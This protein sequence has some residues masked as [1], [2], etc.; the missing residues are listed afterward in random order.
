MQNF[1]VTALLV[2][3]LVLWGC[4]MPWTS[5]DKTEGEE[6]ASTATAAAQEGASQ[7]GTEEITKGDSTDATEASAGMA[8]RE[9]AADP[10]AESGAGSVTHEVAAAG[11]VGASA[12]EKKIAGIT[13]P[14]AALRD[15]ALACEKAP[16]LY[17]V[18]FS[19][20]KGDFIVNVHRGWAPIGA[21]RL[22]NLVN[23][24][25]FNDVAFFR[26]MK[27]FV[28]QFGIS[29][30][31]EISTAWREA[32]IEDDRVIESNTRGFMSF[33]KSQAPNSRTTQVFINLAGIN[34]Y[35]DDGGYA[36]F[37]RVIEGM[38]IV[39]SLYSDYGDVAPRGPG[40]NQVTIES[41]GNAYLKRDFPD[42]DYVLSAAIIE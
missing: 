12:S 2:A 19:T 26:A 18:K 22:Y 23:I 16:D 30:D 8:I 21:D 37:G 39:E 15:P 14:N 9:G 11:T 40:P 41:E 20:T 33:V 35:L 13:G 36:P 10:S 32:T 28:V 5:D 42:L 6:Q 38:E 17:K 25:Y 4:A 29:G 24:G 34:R 27:N 3:L 31:P 1:V 7:D